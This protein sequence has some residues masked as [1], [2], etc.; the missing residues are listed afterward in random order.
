MGSFSNYLCIVHVS[1]SSVKEAMIPRQTV[2]TPNLGWTLPIVGFDD[3]ARLLY[4]HHITASTPRH[5]ES[6]IVQSQSED[7]AFHKMDGD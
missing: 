7:C 5:E 2:P 1:Q 3:R 6:I 4:H